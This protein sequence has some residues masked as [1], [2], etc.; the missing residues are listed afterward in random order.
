[1]ITNE[2]Q[3]YFVLAVMIYLL[4]AFLLYPFVSIDY[5]ALW[6]YPDRYG[7]LIR[8]YS[9]VGRYLSAGFV[10]MA[11]L[12][13]IDPMTSYPLFLGASAVVTALFLSRLYLQYY[14]FQPSW[15]LF[16]FLCT[17]FLFSG[18]MIDIISFREGPYHIILIFGL[19]YLFILTDE[20][21][22]ALVKLALRAVIIAA[23]FATYQAGAV[24]V[25]LL[26]IIKSIFD[27]IDRVPIKVILHDI[28]FD[29]F[30]V[31]AALLVYL[32][33]KGMVEHFSA[34]KMSRPLLDYHDRNAVYERLREHLSA[35]IQ[36]FKTPGEQYK[37][38]HIGI[39]LWFSC[40][41][42][43]I[44]AI[45]KRGLR[46]IP[47]I[48]LTTAMILL[49]QDPMNL[50]VSFYWP[51]LRSS[52]YV[53]LVPGIV[54]PFLYLRIRNSTFQRSAVYVLVGL[55]AVY[56]TAALVL[57]FDGYELRKRDYMLAREIAKE[58][59]ERPELRTAKKIRMSTDWHRIMT[60]YYV[61][62]G[63]LGAL[64][65]DMSTPLLAVRW[66]AIP[67]LRYATGLDLKDGGTPECLE[68]V[69][70]PRL[71]LTVH[72]DEINVCF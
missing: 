62:V 11:S 18:A 60:T 67:F 47:A 64:T 70:P 16:G 12:V 32:S 7:P 53:A 20:V 36:L 59:R 68:I 31:I 46:S 54:I 28:M 24:M 1:M 66:S 72:N 17:V 50:L 71:V 14:K 27:S 69:E 45:A 56:A 21:K 65:H 23:L 40:A 4:I 2:R 13:Q 43:L 33:I 6:Q 61:G 51:T 41:G 63:A 8:D 42:I 37:W 55:A 30:A 39:G 22:P 25:V 35:L 15:L 29:F 38:S 10:Y 58:I 3:S 49:L 26:V 44:C 52:F 5:Y 57:L 48:I 19:S 9:V 34:F